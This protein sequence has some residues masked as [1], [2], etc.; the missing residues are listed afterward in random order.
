MMS[1]TPGGIVLSMNSTVPGHSTSPSG[2]WTATGLIARD[3]SREQDRHGLA[4]L[5]PGNIQ[6]HQRA[7][8]YH[9]PARGRHGNVGE[10]GVHRRSP[11]AVTRRAAFRPLNAP[12]MRRPPPSE[13]AVRSRGTGGQSAGEA[14]NAGRGLS[15]GGRDVRNCGRAVDVWAWQADGGRRGHDGRGSGTGLSER[16]AG[17]QRTGHPR[18]LAQERRI[19]LLRLAGVASGWVTVT[20]DWQDGDRRLGL[21]VFESLIELAHMDGL[22]AA[23]SGRASLRRWR[24]L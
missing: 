14:R 23:V 21:E 18:A 20:A 24:C 22:A 10:L 19:A 3:D 16:M 5:A 2:A 11:P 13:G 12:G 4:V 1:G 9:L 17:Q 7:A 8:P 15:S 6:S